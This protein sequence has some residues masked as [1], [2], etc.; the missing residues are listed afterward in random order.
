MILHLLELGGFADEFAFQ[1]EVLLMNLHLFISCCQ[2]LVLL[3]TCVRSCLDF[4]HIYTLGNLSRHLSGWGSAHFE[5][6][7]QPSIF[8]KSKLPG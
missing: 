6:N 5:K 3:S 8:L 7:K 2:L 4:L 1:L